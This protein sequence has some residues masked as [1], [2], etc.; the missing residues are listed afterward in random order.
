M[1]TL[2]C[3]LD[4]IT[5]T[6]DVEEI[7]RHL[8]SCGKVRRTSGNPGRKRKPVYLDCVTAFDIETSVIDTEQGEQAIMY[9]WQWAFSRDL[10][11]IGRT[12]E[13]FLQVRARLDDYLSTRD[14]KLQL[15]SYVFNLSYEFQFL[16]GI[17]EFDDPAQVFVMDRRKI[18][19]AQMGKIDFRC[20]YIHSNMSLD[21]FCK[22]MGCTLKK[23]TGS[24][25]YRVKRY[26]WT[27]LTEQ[28]LRYCIYDV[29]ALVEAIER[30]MA[31]DGD[32]L[33]TIPLTST[34]YVRRDAKTAIRSE[35]GWWYKLRPIQP[36]LNLFEAL[37]EAFRGGQTHCNR[38]YQGCILE[39]VKSVDR[40]S[41]YP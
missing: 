23:Q 26:P 19:R 13:K 5:V 32:N 37:R 25:D 7:L 24:L 16:K 11:L 35:R 30:E 40:S 39:D 22:K 15:V 41:S 20:A 28:E 4:G 1:T 17:W 8:D 31:L 34:G 2:S 21:V 6:E 36:D 12:W 38:F 3:I 18:L 27:E 14:P 33:E 9:I 29:A 10:V